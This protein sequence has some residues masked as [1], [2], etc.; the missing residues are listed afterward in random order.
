MLNEMIPGSTLSE[1]IPNIEL[2]ADQ[3]KAA[4]V[5]S[6][7]TVANL[8]ILADSASSAGQKQSAQAALVT[9][10]VLD[11]TGQ[12]SAALADALLNTRRENMGEQDTTSGSSGDWFSRALDSIKGLFGFEGGTPGAGSLF[13]DFG[14][15]TF[16]PL[17]GLEAVTKPEQ[18]AAIVAN[19]A[20]GALQAAESAMGGG[21]F[22]PSALENLLTD[23]NSVSQPPVSRMGETSENSLDNLNQT[24][25]QLV[26]LNRNGLEIASKQLRATKGLDGNVMSSVGI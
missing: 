23:V 3:L 5:I 18:M 21:K 11:S 7:E 6:E 9:E 4:G 25:L 24:L 8:K 15:G 16:Q 20:K 19:S 12:I 1:T 10:G 17:H 14:E 2:F 22:S 13:K 26:E